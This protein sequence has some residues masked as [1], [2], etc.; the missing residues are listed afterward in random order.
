MA[1][2]VF[3]IG[4]VLG[5]RWDRRRWSGIVSD[6][7]HMAA[8]FVGCKTALVGTGWIVMKNLLPARW[9]SLVLI[10][11]NLGPP[12]YIYFRAGSKGSVR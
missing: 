3:K 6:A 7:V 2:S 4:F 12:K 5:K 8:A 9:F 11:Q 1:Q 10:F